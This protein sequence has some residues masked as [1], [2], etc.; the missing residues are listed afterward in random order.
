MM[1]KDYGLLAALTVVAALVGGA[2]ASWVILRQAC[3][4]SVYQGEELRLVDREGRVRARMVLGAHGEPGVGLLDGDG[5]PRITLGLGTDGDPSLNLLDQDGR[6][7]ATLRLGK[8]GTPGMILSDRDGK[9][10][11]SAP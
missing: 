10:I 4:A 6:L 8:D 5:R 7:R 1:R 11:W 2:V 3:T 9:V